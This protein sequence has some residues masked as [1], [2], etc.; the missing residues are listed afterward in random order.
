MIFHRFYYKSHTLMRTPIKLKL[1]VSCFSENLLDLVKISSNDKWLLTLPPFLRK[2]CQTCPDSTFLFYLTFVF[3][4]RFS[5][6]EPWEEYLS[7]KV[8]NNTRYNRELVTMY[9]KRFCL[10]QGHHWTFNYCLNSARIYFITQPINA[11]LTWI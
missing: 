8:Q 1:N 6:F 7:Q 4:P 5:L 2:I 10:Y 11:K 9:T 3:L